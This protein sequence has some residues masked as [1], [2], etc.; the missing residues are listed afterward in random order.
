MPIYDFKCEKCGHV[1]EKMQKYD[2]PPPERCSSCGADNTMHKT[3]LKPSDF[4]LKGRHW[5]ARENKV[6]GKKLYSGD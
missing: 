4:R 5:Y 2:D 6:R 1:V 3:I